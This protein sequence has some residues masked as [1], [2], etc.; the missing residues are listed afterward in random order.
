MEET[1]ITNLIFAT[2]TDINIISHYIIELNITNSHYDMCSINI[3]IGYIMAHLISDTKRTPFTLDVGFGLIYIRIECQ[4]KTEKENMAICILFLALLMILIIF[5]FLT[6]E[7]HKLQ[8]L[9][10]SFLCWLI[11]FCIYH[12]GINM[13]PFTYSKTIFPDI[14]FGKRMSWGKN[15]CSNLYIK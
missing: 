15:I 10:S 11:K 4:L 13:V 2:I 9:A 8:S 7:K 6:G 14:Y 3:F 1:K 5:E 12:L